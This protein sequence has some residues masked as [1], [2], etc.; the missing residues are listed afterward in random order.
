MGGSLTWPSIIYPITPHWEA[1]AVC[2]MQ[3]TSVSRYKFNSLRHQFVIF[4]HQHSFRLVA[5][6]NYEWT[7]FTRLSPVRDSVALL[8]R[9]AGENK[10]EQPGELCS[11]WENMHKRWRLK[12]VKNKQMGSIFHLWICF[13]GCDEYEVPGC[14]TFAENTAGRVFQ[15]FWECFSN[16]SHAQWETGSMTL[17]PT[18]CRSIWKRQIKY[19][20]KYKSLDESSLKRNINCQLAAN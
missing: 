8:C 18:N 2:I 7:P 6:L 10:F 20:P 9:T 14:S 5:S 16:F 11:G 19:V 15:M 3:S 1:P 13:I 17:F 12:P 4:W